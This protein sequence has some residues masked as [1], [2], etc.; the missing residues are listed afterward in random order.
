VSARSHESG[1]RPSVIP[2]A[3]GP[4]NDNRWRVV[5]RKPSG[6]GIHYSGVGAYALCGAYI[7][8][9]PFRCPVGA[10]VDCARCC[11]MAALEGA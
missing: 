3:L 5:I 10:Q 6:G 7:S 8:P 2:R 4:A 1:E 9:R 11:R